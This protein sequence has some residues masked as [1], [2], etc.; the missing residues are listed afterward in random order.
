MKRHGYDSLKIGVVGSGKYKN[1]EFVIQMMTGIVWPNK[2]IIVS[3]HSPRNNY[4]NVDIWAEDWANEYCKNKP[5]IHPAKEFTREGFFAR[6]KLVSDDSDCFLCFINKGQYKSGTWNTIKRFVDKGG[7][8]GKD[9]FIF[10]ENG[11]P[12]H[13]NDLPKW[14]MKTG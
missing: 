9:W 1:K 5:I 13:T 7:V 8:Y 11:M 3:G 14:C 12:W 2:D 4:N 6:N 10:D